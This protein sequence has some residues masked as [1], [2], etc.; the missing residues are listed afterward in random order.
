MKNQRSIVSAQSLAGESRPT[1][2]RTEAPAHEPEGEPSG[3]PGSAEPGE[4][5]EPA[6]EGDD[7]PF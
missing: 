6:N 4:P 3:E 7:V 5:G 1:A 2:A